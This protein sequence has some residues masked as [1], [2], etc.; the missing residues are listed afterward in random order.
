MCEADREITRLCAWGDK[1]HRKDRPE[2]EEARGL[3]NENSNPS[4][5]YRFLTILTGRNLPKIRQP[6]G[7]EPSIIDEKTIADFTRVVEQTG[8]LE[9]EPLADEGPQGGPA[10][11]G[12][13]RPRALKSSTRGV[14]GGLMV[15]SGEGATI[16]AVIRCVA[17]ARPRSLD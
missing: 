5:P 3:E 11:S 1:M 10:A 7:P 16:I 17:P 12:A 8:I 9:R 15:A 13:V 4:M 2:R 6:R 14:V